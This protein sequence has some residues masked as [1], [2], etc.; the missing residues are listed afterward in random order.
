VV[1][2]DAHFGEKGTGSKRHLADFVAAVNR[3]HRS[4]PLDVVVLNGDIGHGGQRLLKEAKH[5]LDGLEPPLLVVPGN[6][7][8]VSAKTWQR[9]WG[10]PENQVRRFGERSLIAANTSDK[11]GRYLCADPKW[12]RSRLAAEAGQRDVL[13]FMHITPRR[14]TKHGIDCPSVRSLLARTPNVR[15]VF[16][17]H[18]HDQD[19]IKTDSGMPYLFDGRIGGHWG[20][21]YRGFRLVDVSAG[22]LHTQ[23][24]SV[25]GKEFPQKVLTWTP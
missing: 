5:V 10:T 1:A 16:N 18:D 25:E 9:V 22:R 13:V 7:D 2:S 21:A 11:R 8:G 3:L 20:L 19:G 23:M 15:A 12:L 24:M 17:G 4:T 14:W 6:H